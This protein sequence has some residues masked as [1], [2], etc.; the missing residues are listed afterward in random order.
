MLGCPHCLRSGSNGIIVSEPG[1]TLLVCIACGRSF[2]LVTT[3]TEE[4]RLEKVNGSREYD[5][6]VS[7]AA[8]VVLPG[9]RR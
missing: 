4:H 2:K 1:S 9:Q 3:R 6:Q 5:Y 8:G 7:R